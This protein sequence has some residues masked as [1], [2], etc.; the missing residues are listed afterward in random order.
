MLGICRK[1]FLDRRHL[2]QHHC[3][4][5]GNPSQV[6]WPK[7]PDLVPTN[8]SQYLIALVRFIFETVTI[9]VFTIELIGRTVANTQSKEQLKSYLLSP[10]AITD[11]ASI[12]PYYFMNGGQF[13]G[14]GVEL[15]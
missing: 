6:L 9:V 15:Q 11:L 8:H 10:L 5:P 13:G 3:C 1:Y 12:L 2:A 7:K 14:G 4:D